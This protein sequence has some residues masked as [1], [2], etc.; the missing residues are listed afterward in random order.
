M[1]IQISSSH[2]IHNTDNS[3]TH[4]NNPNSKQLGVHGERLQMQRGVE[5]SELSGVVNG[6]DDVTMWRGVTGE[7]LKVLS[8]MATTIDSASNNSNNNSS[9]SV[10][11][12]PA[13]LHKAFESY[14][15]VL[16]RH[17]ID[18]AVDS[19]YFTHLLEISRCPGA[20]W[21]DKLQVYSRQP[22]TTQLIGDLSASSTVA[23]HPHIPQL[24]ALP[25][26]KWLVPDS[27]REDWRPFVLSSAESNQAERQLIQPGLAGHWMDNADSLTSYVR[28]TSFGKTAYG[29]FILQAKAFVEWKELTRKALIGKLHENIEVSRRASSR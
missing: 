12:K 21:T 7:E 1:R 6:R 29:K 16:R 11:R 4:N 9:S 20:T 24:E 26:G 27:K 17:N 18:E 14:E 15:Q 2:Q 10:G 8:E 3:T 5:A 13:D 19:R 28:T 23:L 22:A 25:I